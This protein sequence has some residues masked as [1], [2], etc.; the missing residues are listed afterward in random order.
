MEGSNELRQDW[1]SFAPWTTASRWQVTRRSLLLSD[2]D[3]GTE[4]PRAK[5]ADQLA[6]VRGGYLFAQL[7]NGTEL[8][9]N[10]QN[11]FVPG[12]RLLIQR[13]FFVGRLVRATDGNWSMQDGTIAGAVFPGDILQAFQDIGM[14]ENMCGSY[15]LLNSY[16]NIAQDSLTSTEEI[17]PELPCDGI[18]IGI[19][20][21][22]RQ[23]MAERVDLVD[24]IDP[25]NC[26]DPRDPTLPRQGCVCQPTGGCV[27]PDGGTDGATDG[28]KDAGT[29]GG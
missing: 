8:W 13:G 4:L 2:T 19:D 7:P 9:L 23:A 17:R 26:P 1:H 28:G 27:F 21:E 29:D 5:F 20:F 24:G 18:S 11:S 3:P 12:F 16:L 15:D 25:Q 10:G 6:F 14:C 22:A